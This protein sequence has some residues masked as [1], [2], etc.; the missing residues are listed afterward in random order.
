MD[1]VGRSGSPVTGGRGSQEGAEMGWR[2]S[3]ERAETGGSGSLERAE[4]G[5]SG[6]LEMSSAVA[7]Q[8]SVHSGR[9]KHV[10]LPQRAIAE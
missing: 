1:A 9:A 8:Q 6:S 2:G 5:G 3:L 4:T 7:L 10:G